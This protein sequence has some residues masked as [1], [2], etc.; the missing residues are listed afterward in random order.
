M[1]I[2]GLLV[3]GGC[4][5]LLRYEVELNVRR[6]FGPSFPFGILVI[7]VTGSFLLGLLIGLA[8]HHGVR[9]AVVTVLGT[10]LLGSYTTFSTFAFDTVALAERGRVVAAATN[11]GV[12][13]VLG[14]GAAA[15]GLAAGHAV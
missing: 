8:E 11:I 13:L 15:L 4:G 1:T 3:A 2:L 6:R 5:A 12:S 9:A 14:L 10:G 7:N